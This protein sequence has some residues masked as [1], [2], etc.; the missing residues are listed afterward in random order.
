MWSSAAAAA[1]SRLSR[2]L[3]VLERRRKGKDQLRVH[4]LLQMLPKVHS[5]R[6]SAVSLANGK[7]GARE[8]TL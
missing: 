4:D 2:V 6:S 1:A 3:S 8:R 7:R 5:L